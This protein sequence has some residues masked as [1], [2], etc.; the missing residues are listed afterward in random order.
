MYRLPPLNYLKTFEAAARHLSFT[1]A[2]DELNC[3]Q[4]SVSQQIRALEQFLGKKL[5]LRFPK[6][7][8]LSNDGQA[9]FPSVQLAIQHLS[10]ATNGLVG[11]SRTQNITVSVPISFATCWLAPRIA[12]F[13][14]L[15]T[16]YKV[17]IQTTLWGDN[18]LEA[19][20]LV[21]QLGTGDWHDMDVKQLTRER[22]A[23]GC[24][25][26]LLGPTRT[27]DAPE[28][29]R[30]FQ[31]IHVLGQ[32]DNWSRWAAKQGVGDLRNVAGMWVDSSII[33]L[34]IAESGHGL[35]ITLE[36]FLDLFVKRGTLVRPFPQTLDT[37][38]G[39]FLLRPRTRHMT[40]A[41]KAFMDWIPGL[42]G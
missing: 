23:V 21:V 29:I 42:D 32:H 22:A 35:S 10:A 4:A 13:C 15:H 30:R 1:H 24:S 27:L 37:N 28:D 19:T 17:T 31:L 26:T 38:Q 16:D 40:S 5:F 41:V 11:L 9:Y 25:A 20:D 33:A 18:D 8:V 2:A 39:F 7:V 6:K 36:S 14:K 12:E 34:Q 3:T